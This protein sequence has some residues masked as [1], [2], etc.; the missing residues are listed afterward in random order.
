MKRKELD[1]MI[2]R[3]ALEK[4]HSQEMACKM[5]LRKYVENNE[6]LTEVAK[7]AAEFLGKRLEAL[8]RKYSMPGVSNTIYYRA[9][10][11]LLEEQIRK[12]E[13]VIKKAEEDS[14]EA[15]EEGYKEGYEGGVNDFVESK[16][17]QDMLRKKG[18]LVIGDRPKKGPK[19]GT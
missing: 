8:K 2:A 19:V 18:L 12:L 10:A 17:R 3:Y 9:Q 14:W 15:H 13:R 7:A 5:L 1:R 11:M 6:L 16:R 4:G